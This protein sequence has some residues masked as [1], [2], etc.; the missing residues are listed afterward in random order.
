MSAFPIVV[1]AVRAPV[2]LYRGC[3]GTDAA[4]VLACMRSNYEVG[5]SPH[6]GERRAIALYMAVSMFEDGALLQR[7]ALRRPSRVG[8]HLARVELL[9]AQGICISDTGSAGHWSVWGLPGQL[10]ECVLD[11]TAIDQPVR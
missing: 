7:V 10:A 11:V 4:A 3:H 2:T 5:R 6:P 9:P 1:D 8:T